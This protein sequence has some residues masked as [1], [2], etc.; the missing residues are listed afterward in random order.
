MTLIVDEKRASG[1]SSKTFKTL[2][3][4]NH[5]AVIYFGGGPEKK[6]HFAKSKTLSF[7]GY[8][9]KFR[10]EGKNILDNALEKKNGFS[11]TGVH[12]MVEH[13]VLLQSAEKKCE[14]NTV[15]S[16]CSPVDDDDSDSCTT[17][18]STGKLLAYNKLKS[19]V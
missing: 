15:A 14:E 12:K 6:L 11:E 5:S 4:N 2:N 7:K 18:P 19:S 10:F 16:G 9:R 1:N 8:F 17:V 3:L 13:N